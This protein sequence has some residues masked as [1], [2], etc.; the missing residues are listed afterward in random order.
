MSRFGIRSTPARDLVRGDMTTLFFSCR[1]CIS[2][3]LNSDP[4]PLFATFS[5]D[6]FLPETLYCNFTHR[7]HGPARSRA[8]SDLFMLKE[9]NN[10]RGCRAF[11]RMLIPL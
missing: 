3:G 5:I 4:R 10:K 9:Y 6:V 8:R 7:Q 2:K 1:P 11:A